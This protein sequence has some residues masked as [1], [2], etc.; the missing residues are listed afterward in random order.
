MFVRCWELEDM[1]GFFKMTELDT[2]SVNPF[3]YFFWLGNSDCVAS[4]QER[5]IGHIKRVVPEADQSPASEHKPTRLPG[6]LAEMLHI[7]TE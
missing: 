1:S 7:A 4:K 6:L 5:S 2:R 3:S